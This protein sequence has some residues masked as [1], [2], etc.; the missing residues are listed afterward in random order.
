[1]S[2]KAWP[3]ERF[4]IEGYY[5]NFS[6][7]FMLP[8]YKLADTSI[9][10][11][12]LGAVNNRVRLKL[13]LHPSSILSIHFAYDLSPRI[14]DPQL[15]EDNIFLGGLEPLEYRFSDI[16]GRVYPEPED[17]ISSFGLFNNLDRFFMT[18]KT[19]FADIFIGR[20]AIAWG[21]ARAVNPTDV[22]APFA[23]NE[24]DK[25]ERR[26]VDAIRIRVPL[27]TMDELDAGF[28]AGKNFD[29]N[30]NAF[31]L[32]GRIYKFKTD[33]SALLISFRKHLLI[34]VDLARSLGGAGF[35]LETAYVIP[36]HFR[37]AKK[38]TENNYFRATIGLDYNLN[39]KTYGFIEYHLNSAGKN[40]PEHYKSLLN[41]SAYQDG[42]VY[43]LGKHYLNI[44]STYLLSPL[45]PVTGLLFLNLSDRSLILSPLLEY[46]IAE[47]IYLSIGAYIGLGKNPELI[48]GSLVPRPF[49]LRS[50]FGTYPD[51]LFTS[52]RIYF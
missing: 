24:L 44:G 25:E 11:P 45:L 16:R 2:L 15:F 12:D 35:W 17:A 32:R 19:S 50:E 4:S 10:D 22:I 33:I 47:N 37:K 6:I 26:G 9:S 34:G 23:F 5:K 28:V 20:Q 43:L 48:L 29:S 21:S 36:D 27:G 38:Q 18:I 7:L 49:I 52:F 40:K 13:S 3:E 39:S 42:S 8:A 14:Q 46:N 30:N 51:M 41:T 31:F 1:M